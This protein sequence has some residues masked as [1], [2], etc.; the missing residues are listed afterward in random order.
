MPAGHKIN[1]LPK[2]E[3]ENS[4]FGK[5][6]KWAV[7][8]G[9][10]VVVFTEFIVICAFLSRFYFDTKLA[11]YF[12]DLKQKKAMVDSAL[13]FEEKFRQIQEKTKI[14][15]NILAS[16]RKPSFILE[17]VNAFLPMDVFLTEIEI[18][19]NKLTLSGFC[20]SENGINLFLNNLINHPQLSNVSINN[21]SGKKESG[22]GI[23]FNVNAVINTNTAK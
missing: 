23:T 19:K 13:I 18:N 1:L 16:E 9:R 3:F 20:L 10:W 14:V 22:T 11:N 7:N 17:S 15:K 6:I 5:L 4:T 21:I 12:D 2:D 8:V